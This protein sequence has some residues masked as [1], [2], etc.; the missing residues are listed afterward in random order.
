M[1]FA[2]E[3]STVLGYARSYCANGG[4]QFTKNINAIARLWN[5]LPSMVEKMNDSVIAFKSKNE[6][7][8][9]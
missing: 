2:Y 9:G 7:V 6:K 1:S 3:D 5:L 8:A 4:Q